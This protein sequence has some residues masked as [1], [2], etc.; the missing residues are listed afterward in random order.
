M[1]NFANA[2]EKISRS[3]AVVA[4]QAHNLKV[5]GSIPASA[6]KRGFKPLFFLTKYQHFMI[7]NYIWLGFILIAV[8]VGVAAA[9]FTGNADVLTEIMNSTFSSAKTGFEI[10]IGLTGVLSLWLGIMKIGEKA[11]VVDGFAK[12]VAPFFSRIFPDVPKGHPAYGSMFMNIAANMLGLDNAATP[13]G[14]KAMKQIG[15]AHV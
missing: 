8:A 12:A 4:R 9:I 14:L 15:R 7:L 2:I 3:R 5:V 11:G 1:C 13:M 10:S 6:T